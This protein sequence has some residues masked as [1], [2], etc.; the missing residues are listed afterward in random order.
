MKDQGE[1]LEEKAQRQ[2]FK[3]AL[4]KMKQ[5]L[6]Y[7]RGFSEVYQDKDCDEANSCIDTLI[8]FFSS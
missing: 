6:W 7:E 1:K 3:E 2:N 5:H 8:E 4:F